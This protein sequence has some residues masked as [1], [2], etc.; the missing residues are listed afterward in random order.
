MSSTLAVG[1][2]HAKILTGLKDGKLCNK[3]ADS[4]ARKWTN[5]AQVLQGITDMAVNFERSRGYVLPSFEVNHT[6]YIIICNSN[7]FYR[8]SK[9]STKEMQQSNV[10]PEKLKCWH[11]QGDHLKKDCP[12][13][14]HQSNSLQ[15]KPSTS[16]DKQCKLIKSF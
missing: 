13:I 3:L 11:C 1:T 7:Q 2:N 6:S 9:S 8:S 10:K 14:P 12:T 16:K 15:A 4:K 5:M